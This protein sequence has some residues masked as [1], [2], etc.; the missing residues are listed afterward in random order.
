MTT[1]RHVPP[2]LRES[3]FR[4]YEP[5]LEQAVAAWP[6]ETSFTPPKDRSPATFIANFRSAILSLKTF[7]WSTTID[8]QKFESILGTFTLIFDATGAVWFKARAARQGRP[9]DMAKA[10][11]RA[12]AYAAATIPVPQ[13]DCTQE[14]LEAFCLLL[15]YQRIGGPFVID[16]EVGQE[17]IDDLTTR[18]N[19]SLVFNSLTKQ[20]ILT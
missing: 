17:Q 14:E 6:S 2:H 9:R 3:L 1:T 5:F 16:G 13:R 15:H 18:Y 8:V 20:T 4:Y 11:P 10:N 12:A 19:V 7:A